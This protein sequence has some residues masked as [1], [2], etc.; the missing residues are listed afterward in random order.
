M[1]F[2][3]EY[4]PFRKDL[5]LNLG[6]VFAIDKE[7]NLFKKTV[8]IM[9]IYTNKPVLYF[10]NFCNYYIK[11]LGKDYPFTKDMC[12]DAMGRNYKGIENVII[13]KEDMNKILALAYSYLNVKE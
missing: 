5:F 11:D 9:D 10:D 6:N 7:G 4:R 12:I 3:L 8:K 13:K 2:K 1:D